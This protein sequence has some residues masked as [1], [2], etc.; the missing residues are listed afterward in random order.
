LN[1][2]KFAL[3][4]ALTPGMSAAANKKKPGEAKK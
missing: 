3:P 2:A 1:S 4:L